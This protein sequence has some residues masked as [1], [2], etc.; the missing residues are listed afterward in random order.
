MLTVLVSVSDKSNLAEFLHKLEKFDELKLIAT[1]STAKFL[2]S[3]NFKCVRVDEITQF[4][5]ILGGRVKT[6]H[7]KIFAG[8]LSRPSAEDRKS[9]GDLG[10]S[11][12][13]LVV[14]NLYPFEQ[15]LKE[16]L[17]E[18]EMIEHID[19]GGPSLIRAAAKNFTRVAVACDPDQYDAITQSMSQNGGKITL[20]LRKQLA[21]AAIQRT[22]N[23]DSEIA[24]YLCKQLGERMLTTPTAAKAAPS[25]LGLQLSLFQELRYGENPHQSAVWYG[26]GGSTKEY[27]GLN[28]F[29]PFEQ[30]QG[31]ELSSNNITDTYCLV[32]ILRDVGSPATCIIKHNNPCGVAVGSDLLDS[33]NKAY[34]TDPT[35]AFG[36][37]FGLTGTV[38]AKMAEKIVENFVEI[39]AAPDF[40]DEALGIFEK[41]KNVRVLRLKPNLLR[42]S[43][44]TPWH[45]R[46]LQD[47]G[48]IVERDMEPPV[49]LSQFQCVTGGSL[50]KEYLADAAFAWAVVKH[51]TSNAIFIAK[52]GCSLGFGIGQT[53]R[54]A[55][56]NIALV[57]AGAKAKNAVLASDAFFPATDNIEAASQAGIKVIIQPGGSVKDKDVIAACEKHGITMLFT[58]QRCFKH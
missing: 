30:L 41:K 29:P 50:G 53:S 5:E 15:K 6:L 14:V 17:S 38:N 19:I 47:F 26:D 54:I 57:Q 28:E 25:Q 44:N 27:N 23:Y 46:H 33:L 34:A 13:D 3:N 22:A 10:I 58:G 18:P 4:P 9:L 40:D 37:I 32:R 49:Q 51:L 56:V 36:G 42:P 48:F 55:S 24:E 1:S 16:G 43:S 45:L 7:P 2:E 39:V 31:K 35:S 52:D 21:H 12:I 11:E 8:I 20:E